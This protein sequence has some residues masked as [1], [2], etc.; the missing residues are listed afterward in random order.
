MRSRPLVNDAM[1]MPERGLT[2]D[3]TSACAAARILYI[4][5]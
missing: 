2:P 3:A 4:V 5:E 1:E